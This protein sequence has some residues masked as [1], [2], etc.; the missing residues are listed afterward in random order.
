MPE[1]TLKEIADEAHIATL[2]L[3]RLLEEQ[4]PKRGEVNEKYENLRYEAKWRWITFFAVLPLALVISSLVTIATVSVCFLG[5][6]PFPKACNII[7]QY[8]EAQERRD[9]NT[10]IVEEFYDITDNNSE[11]I[12]RLENEVYGR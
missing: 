8:S 3:R 6:A 12:K 7:P 10:A 5:T 9:R 1:K 4:Y 2:A 11:R